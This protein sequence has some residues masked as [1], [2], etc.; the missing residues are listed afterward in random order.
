M[1]G[2]EES[3]L[4]TFSMEETQYSAYNFEGQDYRYQGY[5]YVSDLERFYMNMNIG[6]DVTSIWTLRALNAELR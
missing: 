1:K 4:R 2:L 5:S 6:S 3:S